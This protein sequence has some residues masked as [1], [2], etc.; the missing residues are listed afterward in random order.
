MDESS[1]VQPF[2]NQKL[3]QGNKR[4]IKAKVCMECF[5][6]WQG[7]QWKRKRCI[8]GEILTSIMWENKKELERKIK[9]KIGRW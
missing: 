4:R 6:V 5:I 2:R 9:Q 7:D 1:P 8:C 3:L